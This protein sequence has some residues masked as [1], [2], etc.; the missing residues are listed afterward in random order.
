MLAQLVWDCKCR[1]ASQ[2]LGDEGDSAYYVVNWS[3]I[4]ARYWARLIKFDHLSV[5]HWS[6]YGQVKL[7]KRAEIDK[8]EQDVIRADFVRQVLRLP[9]ASRTQVALK[10][11]LGTCI[12]TVFKVNISNIFCDAVRIWRDHS[13]GVLHT[14]QPL[15]TGTT[16]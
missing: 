15:S 12:P 4:K 6:M 10:E 5:L 9:S 11:E 14:Q 8:V 2:K 16:C 13:N 1:V 3:H 7:L